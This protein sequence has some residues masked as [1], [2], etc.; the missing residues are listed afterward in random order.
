[1]NVFQI[2]NDTVLSLGLSHIS[3]N[4]DTFS[5][6][7]LAFGN[8]V[9]FDEM[10]KRNLDEG[11]LEPSETVSTSEVSLHQKELLFV[12]KIASHSCVFNLSMG[13]TGLLNIAEIIAQGRAALT[14]GTTS[15]M[16]VIYASVAFTL[17]ISLCPFSACTAIP[18]IPASAVVL[19]VQVFVPLI[20]LS[21]A[22]SKENE[23]AMTI[24]PPK[25]DQSITFAVGERGRIRSHT[26]I[27]ALVPAG[28]SHLVYLIAF[29]SL[30]LHFD[31]D[32]VEEVCVLD[33][34]RSNWTSVVRCADL[35]TY[36]GQASLSASCLM[37]AELSLCVIAQSTSFL[38]GNSHILGLD[39]VAKNRIW[40]IATMFCVA[41]VFIYLNFTLESGSLQ[42]LPWYFYMIAFISPIISLMVCEL[43]KQK[44]KRLETRA[45][46]LRRLQFETRLGMWSPK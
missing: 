1:M 34:A 36:I 22:F 31:S 37:L 38:F 8:D 44:D 24:V 15:G 20:A 28:A 21:M 40:L 4:D 30:V 46:T 11:T 29:G 25:N 16:F 35:S 17:T 12:S 18:I 33:V 42:A 27:R 2:Y 7:D 13:Q 41:V 26:I 10:H 6:S 43:V 32:V 3:Q 19:Y 5:S 14:A 23:G 39:P 9:L 45:E